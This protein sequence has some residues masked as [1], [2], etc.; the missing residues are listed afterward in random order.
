MNALTQTDRDGRWDELIAAESA[1]DAALARKF[2]SLQADRRAELIRDA[3]IELIERWERGDTAWPHSPAAWLVTAVGNRACDHANKT[4]RRATDAAGLAGTDYESGAAPAAEA[5]HERGLAEENA[6]GLYALLSPT[7][8]HIAVL[9]FSAGIE[10]RLI[11]KQL[12][13]SRRAVY[14]HLDAITTRLHA[15]AEQLA[16]GEFPAAWEKLVCGHVAGT[17]SPRNRAKAA[18]LLESNTD[19][20]LYALGLQRAGEQLAALIPPA[21]LLA[22]PETANPIARVAERVDDALIGAREASENATAALKHQFANVFGRAAEAA[23]ALA[24]SPRSGLGPLI[25]SCVVAGGGTVCA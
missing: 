18:A 12:K 17:L 1:V 24:S 20:Q 3:E 22:P 16:A 9:R 15:P 25:A 13:L 5:D 19:A 23:P 11:A 8:R 4:K 21:A 6:R 14:R 10:P 7:Q 2:G